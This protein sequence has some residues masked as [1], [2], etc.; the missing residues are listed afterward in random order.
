[1]TLDSVRFPPPDAASVADVASPGKGRYPWVGWIEGP[2]GRSRSVAQRMVRASSSMSSSHDYRAFAA[3][4]RRLDRALAALQPAATSIGVDPP[5]GQEWFDLLRDKLLPQLEA[6]PLLVVA[7]VG[8]TN[9]GKSVVFNHLAGEVASAVSP[10]AAH[11]KHPVCLVPPASTI[12]P[13]LA[14]VRGVRAASLAVARRPLGRL[15]RASALLAGR[16]AD[17]AAAVAVGRAR[18]RFRRG[19]QLAACRGRSARWPTCWWPC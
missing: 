1:M 2:P 8:G 11:T 17:A 6:E 13:C 18:R 10:L 5:A 15:A 16:P 7:I 19:G 9:I 14:A 12:R 4:V 3:E